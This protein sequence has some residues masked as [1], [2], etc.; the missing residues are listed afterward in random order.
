MAE[1]N[2]QSQYPDPELSQLQCTTRTK[3]SYG[4]GAEFASKFGD[5][6]AGPPKVYSSPYCM[7]PPSVTFQHTQN[8]DPDAS[9]MDESTRMSEDDDEN[10]ESDFLDELESEFVYHSCNARLVC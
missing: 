1:L 2:M 3:D 5:A 4:T 9:S 6:Q 10:D 8:A 7:V